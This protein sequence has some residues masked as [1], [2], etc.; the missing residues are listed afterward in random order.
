MESAAIVRGVGAHA[1]PML[2]LRQRARAA[3]PERADE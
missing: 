3:M 1:A 2:V